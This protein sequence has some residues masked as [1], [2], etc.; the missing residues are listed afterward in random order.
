M[1]PRVAVTLDD[2]GDASPGRVVDFARRVEELGYESIWAGEAWGRDVFTILTEIACNTS[3]LRLATGIVNV[4]SRSPALVAQS[5]ASLDEL[6]GGRAILGLGSSGEIVV[7]DWHGQQFRK[8]LQRTREY[9]EIVNLAVSGERVSYEGEF[10]RL[11]GFRMSFRPPREHIPIYVAS[12]G[13]KNVA[14]AGELADGWSPIFFSPG[15]LPEFASWIQEGAGAGGRSADAVDIAPWM[16]ACATDD[17]ETARGLARAHLAFYIGGMGQYYNRLFTRYGFAD[18]AAK[19]KELWIEKKDRAAA[20]ALVS[21]E[22]LDAVTVI[23]SPRECRERVLDIHAAGVDLP[24]FFP[25]HGCSQEMIRD[26]IEALA[27][28][29]LR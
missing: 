23:G 8:P 7:R 6:S 3:K 13:P 14:L 2:V 29:R 26:T 16:M 5:I 15:H 12:L 11:K 1:P 25:P 19:I 9:I 28:K 22:M 18:E 20:A 24:V 21:R 27:P 4:F 17:L 10:F